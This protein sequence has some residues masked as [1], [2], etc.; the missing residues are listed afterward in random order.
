MHKLCGI[1]I[2]LMALSVSC[3]GGGTPQQTNDP[4]PTS[5]DQQ[6]QAAPL[7]IGDGRMKNV[8]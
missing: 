4:I 1:A 8:K 2:I 5:P 7:W 3:A 6:Q